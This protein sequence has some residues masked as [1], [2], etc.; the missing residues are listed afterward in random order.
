MKKPAL[1]VPGVCVLALL[2]A[3][4]FTHHPGSA[5]VRLHIVSSPRLN[6]DERGYAHPVEVRIYILNSP[7]AF[8]NNKSSSLWENGGTI[9]D[10]DVLWQKQ[11]TVFPS[12][13]ARLVLPREA[14]LPAAF[15]GIVADYINPRA[16]QNKYLVTL[17]KGRSFMLKLE[18]RHLSLEANLE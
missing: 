3:G 9:L 17:G 10:G 1:L 12:R 6:V 2:S 16:N 7:D 5:G 4:C 8:Q 15:L 13:Q 14:G 18:P 11:I